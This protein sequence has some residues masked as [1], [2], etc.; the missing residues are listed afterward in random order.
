MSY[1][2]S[3]IVPAIDARFVSGNAVPVT[4]ARI[5]KEEWEALKAVLLK[6]KAP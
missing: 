3:K 6:E 4:Q 5:S 2:I 1:P